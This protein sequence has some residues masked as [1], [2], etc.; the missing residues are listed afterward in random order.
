MRKWTVDVKSDYKDI[1]VYIFRQLL[2]PL[3]RKG[4]A[5]GQHFVEKYLRNLVGLLAVSL[6]IY[7]RG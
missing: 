3:V 5:L 6:F 2:E 4:F 7:M 1:K